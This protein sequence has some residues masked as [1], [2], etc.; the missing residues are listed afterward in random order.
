[1]PQYRQPEASLRVQAFCAKHGLDYKIVSYPRAWYE[2][3]ANLVKVGDHYYQ[4]GV[5]RVEASKDK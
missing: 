2:M 4:N 5:Q 3:L 1:M